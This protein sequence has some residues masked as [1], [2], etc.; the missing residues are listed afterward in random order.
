MAIVLLKSKSEVP[1]PSTALE[2]HET[3]VRQ[4][5]AYFVRSRRMVDTLE[6]IASW[7]LLEEQV[8][9]SMRQTEAA[10]KWLVEQGFLEE[11]GPMGL[12]SSIFR[13]NPQKVKDAKRFLAAP[14]KKG[15]GTKAPREP[16]KGI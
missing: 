10:L 3:V 7:R 13:L 1:L 15:T 11:L 12:R 8:S 14:R 5:L 9:L 16:L 4:I 2:L 6:G